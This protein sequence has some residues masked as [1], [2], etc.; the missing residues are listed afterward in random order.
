MT[1]PS[2]VNR[3]ERL[4]GL[5]KLWGAVKYFHPYLAYREDIDWDAALVN[6]IPKVNAVAD[7]YDYA[8][9]VQGMLAALD[10]PITRVIHQEA[11]DT[12]SHPR[13]N[14]PSFRFTPD[15]ILVV[16]IHNYQ[17][18]SDFFG[19]M[20]KLAEIKT[21]IPKA[22]GILF[23]LRAATPVSHELR[24]IMRLAFQSSEITTLLTLTPLITAGERTRMHIGFV[25]QVGGMGF[26]YTSAFQVVDGRRI[27]PAHE[28]REI[29][30]V[31]LINRWS[32]LPPEA[33]ALQ[34]ARKAA[35]FVEGNAGDASL[36]VKT[37]PIALSDGVETE[38]RLGE[39]INEDGSG[40]FLPDKIIPPPRIREGVI[41]N[42]P[43]RSNSSKTSN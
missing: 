15:R 7:T 9:A 17:N 24:E 32:V 3:V 43:R 22:D 26:P 27:S 12:D 2:E 38:I 40:G 41:R 14:Q 36:G 21:K 33:L 1:I 6:T 28:A 29:P 13:E 20:Q 19:V 10:D 16:T 23:D 4:M 37:H 42:S 8:T 18:L 39:L 31:F 5:C 30:I 11:V 35:I 25:P 34:I